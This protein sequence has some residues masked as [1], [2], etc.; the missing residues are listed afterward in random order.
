MKS[1][2]I[3]ALCVLLAA[4]LA[5]YVFQACDGMGNDGEIEFIGNVD[6]IDLGDEGQATVKF[7]STGPWKASIDYPVNNQESGWV[8]VEP[9]TGEAGE[10]IELT[11]KGVGPRP[12]DHTYAAKLRLDLVDGKD[13]TAVP[14]HWSP[15]PK[16]PVPVQS[17]TLDPAGPLSLRIHGRQLVRIVCKPENAT[18]LNFRV[19]IPDG[20]GCFDIHYPYE[21]AK[22]KFMIFATDQTGKATITVTE[23]AGATGTLEVTVTQ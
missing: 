20:T 13:D 3:K 9:Q 7:K 8:V 2:L 10:S 6:G 23:A 17:I 21:E 12:T 14:I 4:G 1:S 5:A 19:N 22:D 18:E 11:L 16:V 15:A